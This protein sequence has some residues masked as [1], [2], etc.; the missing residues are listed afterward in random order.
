MSTSANTSNEVHELEKDIFLHI[1]VL[2]QTSEDGDP[3]TYHVFTI[4]TRSLIELS[5]T[6]DFTGSEDIVIENSDQLVIDTVVEAIS[7]S[8]LCSVK[9]FPHSKLVWQVNWHK[10]NPPRDR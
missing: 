1:K 8:A 9:E 6:I 10:L 4:E 2:N 7:T 5:F 3:V